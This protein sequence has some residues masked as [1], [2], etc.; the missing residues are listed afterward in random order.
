VSFRARIPARSTRCSRAD[1]NVSAKSVEKSFPLGPVEQLWRSGPQCAE[2]SVLHS[3][4]YGCSVAGV[5]LISSTT[6]LQHETPD[7]VRY[8]TVT[9]DFFTNV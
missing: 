7:R 6:Q 4:P 1:R 5:Q 2:R 9:F 3:V 8:R